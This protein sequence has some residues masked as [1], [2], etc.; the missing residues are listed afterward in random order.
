MQLVERLSLGQQIWITFPCDD[1]SA[2]A[3]LSLDSS[4]G[5][6]IPVQVTCDFSRE[7][8]LRLELLDQ[9]GFAPGSGPISRRGAQIHAEHGFDSSLEEAVQR[10]LAP[11]R[12]RI[13]AKLRTRHVPE[14]WL[15]LHF[16]DATLPPEGVESVM[17]ACAKVLA[18]APFQA[19]FLVGSTEEN[20]LCRLLSGSI[21]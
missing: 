3:L 8:Q 6:P 11:L 10:I 13:E 5:P 21:P 2:D 7:Q 19:A 12:E 17:D 16:G 9:Q 15:L 4:M 18:G 14:T 20:R 1:G